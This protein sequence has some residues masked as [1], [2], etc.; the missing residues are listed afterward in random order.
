MGISYCFFDINV[1]SILQIYH[2]KVIPCFS[3][4]VLPIYCIPTIWLIAIQKIYFFYKCF[5]YN[6]HMQYGNKKC[7]SVLLNQ[8]TF[9]TFIN[10]KITFII[11]YYYKISNLFIFYF[12][13][14]VTLTFN[15]LPLLRVTVIVAFPFLFFAVITPFLLTVAIFL[16]DDL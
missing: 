6:L 4:F 3:I 11:Y 5:K 2:T 16:L 9:F 14:T 10:C 15:F 7:A 1:L 8:N 13:L 12:L